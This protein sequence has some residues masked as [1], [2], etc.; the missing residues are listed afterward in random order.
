MDAERKAGKAGGVGWRRCDLRGQLHQ[1]LHPPPHLGPAAPLAT[2][3]TAIFIT[4][5]I[6]T[7]ITA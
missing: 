6:I 5:V 4:T 3:D 1:R 2:S 7:I